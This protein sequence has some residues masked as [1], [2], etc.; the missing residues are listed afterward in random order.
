MPNWCENYI[1]IEGKPEVVRDLWERAQKVGLLQAMY[2]TPKELEDTYDWCVDNWGTKWNVEIDP[3]DEQMAYYDEGRI[4][5]YFES[6]W[7]PPLPAISNYLEGFENED[8]APTIRLRYHEGG[9]CFVGDSTN[10]YDD[11]YLDNYWDL[12]P[13]E[14]KDAIPEHLDELFRIT[15]FMEDIENED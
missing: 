9:M 2:P 6:A 1:E 12:S 10:G 7:A 8:D 4:E 13:E 15:E 11:F 5:G 3:N 14:R